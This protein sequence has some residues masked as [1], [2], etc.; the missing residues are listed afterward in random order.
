VGQLAS[1]NGDG[2]GREGGGHVA[3]AR[4]NHG[5][6]GGARPETGLGRAAGAGAG[7]ARPPARG[8]LGRRARWGAAG[9]PVRAGPERPARCGT[10]P[11]ARWERDACLGR[12]WVGLGRDGILGRVRTCRYST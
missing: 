9:P 7:G 4:R 6:R 11:E 5:R 12:G 8:E 2:G 10:R 3:G 1:A